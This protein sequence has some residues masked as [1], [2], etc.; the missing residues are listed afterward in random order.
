MGRLRSR[1]A[2]PGPT[3]Y[4]TARKAADKVY[5]L[6][7]PTKAIVALG[8]AWPD[9]ASVSALAY[10]KS[11]PICLSK[12]STLGTQT[13]EYLSA[14][15]P[16]MTYVIGSETVVPKTVYDAIPAATGKSAMRLAGANRYATAAAVARQSVSITEGFSIQDIYITT[17]L[18]YPDALSGGVLAG[19]QRHPLLLTHPDGCPDGTADFLDDN[20]LAI[21]YLWILGGTGAISQTGVAAIDSVMMN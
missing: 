2:S 11:Y 18:N 5:S 7:A 16:A 20:K 4:E 19:I 6:K 17:G 15:K 3:A 9:A 8:T 10:A 14:R 1:R 12:P 21:S 13:A